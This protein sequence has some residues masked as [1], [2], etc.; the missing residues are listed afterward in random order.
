MT[1]SCYNP[2]NM[3]D[4]VSRPEDQVPYE[5]YIADRVEAGIQ[6]AGNYIFQTDDPKVGMYIA[7][8]S[9]TTKNAILAGFGSLRE[10]EDETLVYLPNL[11]DYDNRP[12]PGKVDVRDIGLGELINE[13]IINSGTAGVERVIEVIPK[14]HRKTFTPLG[15]MYVCP[16]GRK[17]QLGI[18]RFK[19]FKSFPSFTDTPMYRPLSRFETASSFVFMKVEEQA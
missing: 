13:G 7:Y 8:T 19:N 18:L 5:Q 16:N 14:K 1:Y 17:W 9:T 3:S 12:V 10:V 11:M 6:E 15:S 4:Q 2:A